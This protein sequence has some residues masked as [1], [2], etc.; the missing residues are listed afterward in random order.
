MPT[1]SVEIVA[2]ALVSA[3]QQRK[4]V[5]AIP[6]AEMLSSPDE[7]YAVQAAVAGEMGWF[8]SGAPQY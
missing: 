8:S 2:H 4:V 5:A 6:F 1:S 3:R 7:A